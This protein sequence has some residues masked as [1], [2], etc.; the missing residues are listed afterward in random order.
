MRRT[1]SSK[2][3]NFRSNRE[4]VASSFRLNETLAAAKSP[5]RVERFA[6][7]NSGSTPGSAL[8]TGST[9]SVEQPL[10]EALDFD[11]LTG[12]AIH[13]LKTGEEGALRYRFTNTSNQAGTFS[14]SL[15][16]KSFTGKTHEENF[17]G[18]TS[19]RG[20]PALSPRPG[21]RRSSATGM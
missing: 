20:I 18:G 12:N 6:L 7:V 15:Q 4:E 8:L 17:T 9:L 11:I 13:V 1:N 10:I 5:I 16:F 21:N 3:R 14:I 2:P 19:A